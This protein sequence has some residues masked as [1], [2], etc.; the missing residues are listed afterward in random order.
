MDQEAAAVFAPED[1]ELLLDEL[2]ELPLELPAAAGAGLLVDGVL[3]GLSD[4]S[5]FF[6]AASAAAP[7]VSALT[8]LE[9]ESLR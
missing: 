9:R 8:L 2:D 3:D 6:G 1:D 5:D 4:F 7:E